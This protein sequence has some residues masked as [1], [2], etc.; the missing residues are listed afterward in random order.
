MN[1]FRNFVEFLFNSYFSDTC[2]LKQSLT[3]IARTSMGNDAAIFW[4]WKTKIA[5][6]LTHQLPSYPICIAVGYFELKRSAYNILSLILCPSFRFD[7]V[8]LCF[9]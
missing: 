8:R 9:A 5:E 2:I 3:M 1:G 6:F 7:S 4:E